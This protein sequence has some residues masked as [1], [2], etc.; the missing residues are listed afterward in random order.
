MYYKF[1][2]MNFIRKNISTLIFAILLLLIVFVP[3]TKAYFLHGLMQIG[4]FSPNNEGVLNAER[5][6]LSGVKFKDSKGNT[7]DLGN[8]EGKII[9]INFWATWCP[10]CIAEMPSLNKLYNRF[11]ND[12]SVVF[13]FVD[14]DGDFDTSLS[15]LSKRKYQF[16][17]YKMEAYIPD[18]FFAGTLPTT[19]IID[20]KGRLSFKHEG[21]A[22]YADEKFVQFIEKLKASNL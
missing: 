10:P 2:I 18:Q 17:L 22:N 8:L 7:L 20:K 21:L 13:L 19:V 14:A 1:L 4:L 12:K 5:I 15:F 3:N 6:N 11:K 16:P 9:F